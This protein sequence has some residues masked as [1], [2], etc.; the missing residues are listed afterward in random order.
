[1]VNFWSAYAQSPEAAIT[2]TFDEKGKIKS[3]EEG[4]VQEIAKDVTQGQVP[5]IVAGGT[6]DI[7]D[8]AKVLNDLNAEHG[9]NTQLLSHLAKPLID[10]VQSTIGRESFTKNW[11]SLMDKY[12]LPFKDDPEN[13]ANLVGG[14]VNLG[15]IFNLGKAGVKSAIEIGTGIKKVLKNSDN[16]PPLGPTPVLAGVGDVKASNINQQTDQIFDIKKDVIAT[17]VP[18]SIPAEELI[19]APQIN[20]TMA[21]INTPTGKKQAAIFKELEQRGNKTPEQLFNETGVYRGSDNKLRWEIDDR[22]ASLIDVDMSVGKQYSLSKV[23]KF[24]DLYKEYFKNIKVEGVDYQAL[25]NVKVEFISDKKGGYKASYTSE[26]DTIQ[27]NMEQ[28]KNFSDDLKREKI[29]SSLLHEVQH[30]V[31]R[32]EGFVYGS[33]IDSELAKSANYEKYTEAVEF[34]KNINKINIIT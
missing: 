9:G 18:N 31:Q 3:P 2:G 33:S 16:F 34:L 15:G 14:L 32:R 20:P 1:M 12:D 6:S 28:F 8:L 27:I 22:N 11:N 25:K 10:K 23:L 5:A 24:D 29:I 19:N 13:P 4:Q 26:R 7:I 21:G 30:A 17:N